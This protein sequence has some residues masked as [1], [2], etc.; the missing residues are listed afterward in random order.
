MLE[1][2]FAPPAAEPTNVL[3]DPEVRASPASCP[4]AV[5]LSPLVKSSNT[6]CPKPVFAV[7]VLKVP[8]PASLL[9]SKLSLKLL[10]L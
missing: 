9:I 1:V 5:L 10:I 4:T 7:A 2:W 8:V 6:S 3:S